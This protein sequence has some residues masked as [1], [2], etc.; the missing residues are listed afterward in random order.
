M[1]MQM[2][3]MFT[4]GTTNPDRLGYDRNYGVVDD[5]WYRFV[6]RHNIWAQSHYGD[7]QGNVI[8]CYTDKT[9]PVG[10][11]PSRDE[12]PLNGT[13]DECEAAGAGSR[14]DQFSHACTLPYAQR[15]TK[16]TPF[17]YGPESDPTL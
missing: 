15:Q 10:A 17:Y 8:P 7:A 9:T 11:L 13:D 3:G 6:S 16:T 12:D 2:F 14:C 5:K 1:R 4:T